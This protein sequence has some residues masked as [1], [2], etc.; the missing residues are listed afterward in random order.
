[1]LLP[2]LA[3]RTDIT[4]PWCLANINQQEIAMT[5]LQCFK[6]CMRLRVYIIVGVRLVLRS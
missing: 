4:Q 5:F 2:I 3:R 6:R 1:V